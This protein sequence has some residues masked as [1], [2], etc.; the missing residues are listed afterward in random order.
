MLDTPL[1]PAE[2]VLTICGAVPW[3]SYPSPTSFHPLTEQ[4]EPRYRGQG[5]M[6]I[7]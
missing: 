7:S 4:D 6:L 5:M 2:P 3:R 1:K